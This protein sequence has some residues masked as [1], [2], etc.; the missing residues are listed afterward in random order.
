MGLL[1][2]LL[3][4]S[5]IQTRRYWYGWWM[6]TR[7]VWIVRTKKHGAGKLAWNLAFRMGSCHRFIVDGQHRT[8][9]RGIYWMQKWIDDHQ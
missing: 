8:P 5:I 7:A 9:P 6:F 3:K 4:E 1:K 2:M